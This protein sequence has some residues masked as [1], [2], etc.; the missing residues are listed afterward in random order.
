[1]L[2]EADNGQTLAFTASTTEFDMVMPSVG[3]ST[4]MGTG[5]I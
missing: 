3:C 5:G 1:M 4:G 2:E